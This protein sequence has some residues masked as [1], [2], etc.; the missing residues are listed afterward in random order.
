MTVRRKAVLFIV[1]LLVTFFGIL[2]I[3]ANNVILPSYEAVESKRANDEAKRAAN[4]I[5]NELSLIDSSVVDWASWND[6]Y[7]YMQ[8]RDPAYVQENLDESCLHN[9]KMNIIIY[10]DVLGRPVIALDKHSGEMKCHKMRLEDIKAFISE[11][12][13]DNIEKPSS[14]VIYLHGIPVLVSTNPILRN[15]NTGPS[16]GTLMMARYID[17]KKRNNLS[18]V[19]KLSLSIHQINGTWRAEL[20]R[21]V[22]DQTINAPVWTNVLSNKL[23]GGYTVLRGPQSN[24]TTII[25]TVSHRSIIQQGQETLKRFLVAF[26]IAGLVIGLAVLLLLDRGILARLKILDN[27]LR[28]IDATRD[29]SIR[30]QIDGDPDKADELTRVALTVNSMLTSLEAARQS[31]S[32]AFELNPNM[33]AIKSISDGTYVE[34]NQ[35]FLEK[36][37]YSREEVI[38]HKSSDLHIYEDPELTLDITAL[39]KEYGKVTNKEVTIKQKFGTKLICLC[40]AQAMDVNGALNI[41]AVFVDITDLKTIEQ[42]RISDKPKK[43]H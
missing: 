4:T 16:R 30:V 42:P 17:R 28:R 20:K 22:R 21:K 8:T 3:M 27:Y 34:V 25:E 35:A 18:D 11:C 13:P 31:F 29:P 12:A 10:L 23:I 2:Y 7:S 1:G 9:L 5:K 33:M 32:K 19:L 38:G 37:C 41:L 26:L 40:S 43:L 36:T 24:N 15:N 6:T 39:V 14:G